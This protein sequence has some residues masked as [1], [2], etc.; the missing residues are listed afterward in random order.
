MLSLTR[1]GVPNPEGKAPRSTLQR[2]EYYLLG[3][4]LLRRTWPNL[5]RG[6]E[7]TPTDKVLLSDISSLKLEYLDVAGRVRP[8]WRLASEMPTA[9]ASE[10]R[11]DLPVAVV[12]KLSLVNYGELEWWLMLPGGRRALAI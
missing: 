12:V 3:Q 5:D 8:N 2:V 4:Q 1:A 9:N 6:S 7:D 10:E 11:P